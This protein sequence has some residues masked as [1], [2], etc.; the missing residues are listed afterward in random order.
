VAEEELKDLRFGD[1]LAPGRC[2]RNSNRA[3]LRGGELHFDVP[4]PHLVGAETRSPQATWAYSWINP[5]IRSS[6]ATRML[7]GGTGR[8]WLP[9]VVP[10]PVSGAAGAVVGHV[11][12]Q[13]RLQMPLTYEQ[14]PIQQLT[15]DRA[16]PS[17]RDRV[18]A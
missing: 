5:P 2:S 7:A 6:R 8:E 16:D 9:A 18:R 14:H 4:S 1:D 3:R 17:L 10:G 11:A 15:T 12:G 13:R